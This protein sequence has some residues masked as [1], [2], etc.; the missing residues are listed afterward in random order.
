MNIIHE[1][2]SLCEHCYSHVPAICFERDGAIWLGKTCN[3]HGYLEHLVE[4][5]A[6]FYLNYEYKWR[7]LET[8]CLDITNR[9]NLNC[10]QCYQ[11]PDN[12]STDKP[13]KFILDKI[14]SY[15][16]DEYNIALM[17]A[18]PTTR[19]DLSRLV[20]GINNLDRITP[21]IMVLTNG[22]NLSNKDYIKQFVGID[23]LFWT[24]GLNHPDYQ[25]A[26]VREK[27]MQGIQ[28]CI[29]F[30]Q[31][32]KNVSY[33]L[34][35]FTQLEYCL[36]EI[37]KFK[38]S[39]CKNYRIRCGA[40]IG[41]SP[42]GEKIFM[43]GLVKEVKKICDARGWVIEQELEFGNRA[44]YSIFINGVPVKIIQW[45]DTTT[46]DLEELQT[47]SWADMLPAMP[48]SPLIHQVM[49]R[50][51]LVNKGLPLPDLIPK[52]YRRL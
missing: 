1:T 14:E 19:K 2:I 16:H 29:E 41:R 51:G 28:N 43:S 42:A 44:H 13:Y 40:N 52:K 24:F 45:P 38:T 39:F 6:E 37:Q 10:P 34:E 4:P 18:E 11:M 21:E 31:T 7:P 23:N 47:E 20:Q 35:D 15:P 9:C 25:G 26:S 3:S 5:D 48:I 49:L 32:I 50:D 8:Y 30:G 46:I 22:V 27:Q 12:M 17:G 36:E 33:T